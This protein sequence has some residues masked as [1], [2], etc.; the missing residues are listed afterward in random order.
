MKVDPKDLV[1]YPQIEEATGVLRSTL[2]TWVSRGGILPEPLRSDLGVPVW[3]RS[4]IIPAV[5]KRIEKK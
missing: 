2:R 5:M 4:V 3:E 1:S